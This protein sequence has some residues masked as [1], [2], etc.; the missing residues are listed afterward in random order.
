MKS[1]STIP[2]ELAS[3]HSNQPQPLWAS[4]DERTAYIR[5]P[6]VLG[7]GLRRSKRVAY[8]RATICK[9]ESPHSLNLSGEMR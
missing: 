8:R 5:I 2:T 3:S 6:N 4:W 1:G 9:D 7:F